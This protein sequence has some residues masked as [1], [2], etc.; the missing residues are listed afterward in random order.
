MSPEAGTEVTLV[1]PTAPGEAVEAGQ[2][3]GLQ[4]PP[5]GVDGPFNQPAAKKP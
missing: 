2:D 4:Q 5:H 3:L 1:P